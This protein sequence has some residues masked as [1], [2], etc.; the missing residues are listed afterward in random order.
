LSQTEFIARIE[1]DQGILRKL[2][3][4]YARDEAERQ[5]LMQESLLNAWKA[6]PAFRGEAKFSTWLYRICLNTILTQ[7]RRDKPVD[8]VAD[9][10]RVSPQ[11][12]ERGEQDDRERLYAAI[13]TLPETDRALVGLHLDGFTNQEASEVLGIS[14]NHFAVKLHRIKQ[15]LAELLKPH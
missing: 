13:R 2:V 10:E 11:F 1:A 7:R 3:L 15:R 14:P 9:L 5:D 8:R 4:L 12:D 6:W